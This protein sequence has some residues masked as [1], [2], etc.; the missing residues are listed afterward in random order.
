MGEG[1]TFALVVYLTRRADD[2]DA[3][4]H[5]VNKEDVRFLGVDDDPETLEYFMTIINRL[6]IPCDT[7]GSGQEAMELINQGHEYNLCFIDWKMPEMNGIE[8]S[9]I[10]K[11][12]GE[13][14]S[15]V[16]M[17]SAADWSMVEGEA[18]EAGVDGFLS[19]PLFQSKVIDCINSHIGII[20]ATD[21]SD[22]PEQS[23]R[24]YHILLA[25]DVEINR[26]IV[27]ALLEPTQ[28]KI[29][30]AE[31]GV[32]AVRMFRE[33]PE[34]YNMIFMDIQMPEMDGYE[35]TKTIRA[36]DTPQAKT[37]PIIA[38]TANVFKEDIEKCLAAGM[39]DHLG[40]PINMNEVWEKLRVY[41][42][43]DDDV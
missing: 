27:L 12:D 7:A 2:D 8:L 16:V 37:I 5:F 40:K 3:I 21:E 32:V 39:N 43:T 11:T 14:K 20:A 19:K 26:E 1:A 28:L 34:K 35:A 9:R 23:F 13:N 25:E 38:M 10:M 15:V 30:C 4:L 31:N 42:T 6:G 29:D 36:F 24:G 17:I 22:E 41:L 18:K 33:A